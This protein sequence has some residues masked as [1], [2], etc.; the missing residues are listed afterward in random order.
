MTDTLNI[1]DLLEGDALTQDQIDALLAMDSGKGTFK[2]RLTAVVNNGKVL[3]DLTEVFPIT[4]EKG[5]CKTVA[6][7]KSYMKLRMREDHPDVNATVISSGNRVL[8]VNLD[9]RENDVTPDSE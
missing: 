8:L 9:N 2:P 5:V 1:D 4:G 3:S 7:L 6:S